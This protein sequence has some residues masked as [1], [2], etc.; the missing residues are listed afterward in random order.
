VQS[1][2]SLTILRNLYLIKP[3]LKEQNKIVTCFDNINR[4]INDLK[5]N[6]QQQISTLNEYRKSLIHECVTGKRRITEADVQG[7]L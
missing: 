2:L 5:E 1:F 4:Q 7:Q 3:H 6:I